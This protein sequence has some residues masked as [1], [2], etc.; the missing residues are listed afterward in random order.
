MR[1][2]VALLLALLPATAS[3]AECAQVILKDVNG[4]PVKGAQPLVAFIIPEFGPVTEQPLPAGTT[5]ERGPAAACPPSLI[6]AMRKLFDESCPT[7]QARAAAAKANNASAE[8]INVQCRR[9][10]RGLNPT[11]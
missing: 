5:L 1:F 4:L 7:E 2:A 8:T 10:Y 11:P 6:A 3:A 9:I